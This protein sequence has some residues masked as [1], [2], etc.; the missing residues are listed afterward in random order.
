MWRIGMTARATILK[1]QSAMFWRQVLWS[2][3]IRRQRRRQKKQLQSKL[4][5][6]PRLRDRRKGTHPVFLQLAIKQTSTRW[7]RQTF[8][9]SMFEHFI[10]SRKC[11]ATINT[12]HTI[13]FPTLQTFKS[14]VWMRSN[15]FLTD[16]DTPIASLSIRARKRRSVANF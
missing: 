8:L 13:M 16:A 6:I 7:F 1:A 14:S 15:T 4:G 12:L 5:S 10:M 9:T 11:V 2:R 3:S